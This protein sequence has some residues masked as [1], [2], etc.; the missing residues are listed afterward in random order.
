MGVSVGQASA[1]ALAAYLT[2][3]FG[4]TSLDVAITSRWP[5]LSQE[6]PPRAITIVP[7]GRRQRLE[8]IPSMDVVTRT[9]LTATTAQVGFR[10]GSFVQPIQLDVWAGYDVDRDSI[11]AQLDVALSASMNV[12]LA[13]QPG[14][15]DDP[16]R[17]GI[18]V[19]LLSDDCFTGNIDYWFDEPDISD[20]A[21]S[22][23]RSEYRA[24]YF[25][26]AR[27]TFYQ[28]ATVPRLV[29]ATLVQSLSQTGIP[30]V[31]PAD[32]TTITTNPTPPPT[33]KI[34]RGTE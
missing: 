26:E 10:L 32:T 33:Y 15:N 24:T 9:N 31:T 12:T 23:Q 28:L 14:I 7:V 16:V 5:S 8:V 18:V 3:V 13:G 22:V 27:G 29:S 17:D 19:P 11:I 1:N 20:A 21:A 6:L 2:T 25:G 34:T 30:P 4:Y